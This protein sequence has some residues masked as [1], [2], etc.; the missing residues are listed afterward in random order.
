MYFRAELCWNNVYVGDS[1]W[2]H[3]NQIICNCETA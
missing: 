1:F 3:K 2:S